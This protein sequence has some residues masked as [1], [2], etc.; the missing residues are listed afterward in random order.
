MEWGFS[1]GEGCFVDRQPAEGAAMK[2][3]P[4][5]QAAIEELIH[6]IRGQKVILDSDLA[7]IYGVTTKRFN[8][9]VKRNAYRF[10]G[11]F[12]FRLI[13]EEYQVLISQFAIS[14]KACF[15]IN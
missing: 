15:E 13:R 5:G 6:V 12:M 11:D 2:N 14:K 9:Q 7:R 10:P 1:F 4:E 8:E 3:K